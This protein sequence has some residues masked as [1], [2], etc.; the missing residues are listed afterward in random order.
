MHDW[1][2]SLDN[3]RYYHISQVAINVKFRS[4]QPIHLPFNVR[5]LIDSH[6]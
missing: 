1:L 2:F 6:V 4:F 5:T 3:V